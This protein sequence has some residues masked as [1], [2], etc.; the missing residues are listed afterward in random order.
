MISFPVPAGTKLA[1]L[2]STGHAVTWYQALL[3]S[4]VQ[5][6]VL[7]GAS[8]GVSADIQNALDAGLS[9]QLFQGY[10]T[11]AWAVPAQATARAN[12]LVTLAKEVQWPSGSGAPVLWL[13]LESTGNAPASALITWITNW[14]RVVQQAGFQ[15]GLY[16][17]PGHPLSGQQLW[18][19]PTITHYWKSASNVPAIPQRGYQ[20]IQTAFNQSFQ[21]V[22]VDYDTVQAD[23]LGSLP[24]AVALTAGPSAASFASL[25]QQVAALQGTLTNLASQG[26]ATDAKLAQ[27]AA[28]VEAHGT[29]IAAMKTLTNAL[30]RIFS[31]LK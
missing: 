30:K 16:N 17:G 13:D 24:V 15:A 2:S 11:P 14:G 22:A 31:T 20:M 29:D 4:G 23:E 21:G 8:P 7:D 19:I 1:D 10:F 25:Q 12:A 18:D 27:V 3:Q 5:G 28:D 26:N 9:V 6:V